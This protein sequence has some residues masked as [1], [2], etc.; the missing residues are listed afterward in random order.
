V[1]QGFVQQQADDGLTAPATSFELIP[2]AVF[3]IHAGGGRYTILAAWMIIVI[4]RPL[5]ADCCLLR[6]RF[7]FH[8]ND[9]QPGGR[10]TER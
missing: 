7:V 5:R 8:S 10:L 2:P 3:S 4:A 6:C 1:V 9:T